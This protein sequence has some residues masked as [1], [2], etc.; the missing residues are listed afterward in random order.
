[1]I[2]AERISVER[3]IDAMVDLRV[4]TAN[5]GG[6]SISFDLYG[7]GYTPNEPRLHFRTSS[8]LFSSSPISTSGLQLLTYGG[9][10]RGCYAVLVVSATRP[11]A[12]SLNATV[13][14]DLILRSPDPA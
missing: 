9:T 1:M 7:D 6:G 5:I 8:P 10:V 12:V 14:L 4:H 13:S 2:V 3:F 11:S